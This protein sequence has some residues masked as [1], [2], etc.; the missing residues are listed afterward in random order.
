VGA[1]NKSTQADVKENSSRPRDG[2]LIVQNQS[3][4]E[5]LLDFDSEN[6]Y[7]FTIDNRMGNTV[8]IET[9]AVCACVIALTSCAAP[10]NGLQCL[11]QPGR[12]LEL[13]VCSDARPER[14]SSIQVR[15][16]MATLP[17]T[18]ERI[19]PVTGFAE[20]TV[21]QPTLAAQ[22]AARERVADLGGDTLVITAINQ[23]SRTASFNTTVRG[24]AMR[25]H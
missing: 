2:I 18:C 15:N 22:D 6:G 12:A 9:F 25:C 14:A 11:L 8:N 21:G 17:S 13:A 5:R 1:T 7:P 3:L 20:A 19:G 4:A 16:D 23:N 10:T 24:T